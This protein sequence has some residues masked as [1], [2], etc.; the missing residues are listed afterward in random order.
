MCT[1]LSHLLLNNYWLCGDSCGVGWRGWVGSLLRRS[2]IGRRGTGVSC[3]SLSTWNR[4][5]INQ[6]DHS[7][8][9]TWWGNSS[10]QPKMKWSATRYVVY[11]QK[12]IFLYCLTLIT[13]ADFSMAASMKPA[14]PAYYK[15]TSHC[16]THAGHHLD[17]VKI[18][19]RTEADFNSLTNGCFSDI[20]TSL[21]KAVTSYERLIKP[22]IIPPHSCNYCTLNPCLQ[23]VSCI[24]VSLASCWFWAV[25]SRLWCTSGHFLNCAEM[26]KEKIDFK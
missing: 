10:L 14:T 17:N 22:R 21:H 19:I 6:S 5:E 11:S 15:P 1:L 20:V 16:Y 4:D 2:V 25:R 23:N 12:S 13:L 3:T 26:E 7:N 18:Y 8:T 24:V 9:L